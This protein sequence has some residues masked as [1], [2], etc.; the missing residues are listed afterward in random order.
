[1]KDQ[2]RP[3]ARSLAKACVSSQKRST[4]CSWAA[5][6]TEEGTGLNMI[7]SDLERQ[8]QALVGSA[9]ALVIDDAQ[10]PDLTR[11][12]DVSPAVGLQVEPLDLHDADLL[13]P[14]RQQADLR[15][16]QV[17]DG[18][19]LLA[20]KDPARAPSRR[21]DLDVD[22]LLDRADELLT[23]RRKL[24]VHPSLKRRHLAPRDAGFMVAPD[25]AAQDMHGGVRAH[26]LDPPLP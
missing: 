24:E 5:K 7:G 23:H 14:L 1:M 25:H 10:R 6:S 13:D 18:E 11:V 15:A 22:R 8:H 17:G 21:L 20:R 4:S 12:G 19:G 9:L 3:P 26:E 2:R 16:D